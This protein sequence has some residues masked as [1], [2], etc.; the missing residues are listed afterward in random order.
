MAKPIRASRL[1]ARAQGP[2]LPPEPCGCDRD[3]IT[4][5]RQLFVDFFQGTGIAAGRDPATRPVFLRL[6]G[7]A[8]GWFRVEPDL[9]EPL[10][11]GVLG[12]HGEYPAWIRFSSDVQPGTPDLKSTIGIAI[13]LFGV[14]GEK[15]LPPDQHAVTHDFV[16]QNHDVFFVDTAR[17]MCEF[18][19]QSLHGKL[20]DYLRAHPETGR[21]LD[22]MAKTVDSVLASAYWSVLPSR[23]GADRYVKYKIEP[24]LVPP[25]SPPDHA[26]PE[27]LAADLRARLRGG[28]A[29][30]RFLIQLRSDEAAMPL[31]RA[32]VRWDESASPPVHVA[33]LVVPMQDVAARGQATYGENLSFNPWRAL[34]AHAPVGS[35]AE[36]RKIVYAA[37]AANRRDV[38]GVPRGEPEIPRP[39]DF[40]G[41]DYPAARDTAIVRAAIHPAIGVA[42][43]GPSDEYYI[44]PEVPDSPPAQPGE[45]RDATGALKRQAAR[46]RIFGYNAAGEVVR[47]LTADWA[48]IEWRVRVANRK[49]AWY[50][51]QIALD[52]PEAAGVAV[53]LRNAKVTGAAREA[54][55]IDSGEV[56]ISG[57]STSGPAYAL[58]GTFTGVRVALGELRTDDAGR[59]V[60]LGGHGVA[61]SPTGAPIYNDDDPN[62]FINADDW[63]DDVSDGPVTASVSIAGRAIVVEPAWVMTAPPD[64]A[65]SIKAVRTLYDLLFDLYVNAGWLAAPATIGFHRDVHPILLRLVGLQW[66]NQGFLTQYGR[67]APNDFEQPDYVARLSRPPAPGAYD[68]HGELRRQVLNSFRSPTVADGNQLP[69]PWLYG[70]AM[71]YPAGSSP[72]Q[73]AA[74]SWTQYRILQR[75]AAGDFVDDT[76]FAPPTSLDAVPLAA[77]PATLDRA[78]LEH[79]LADAFHPG[80]EVT[81]PIR[82][83]TMF[84]APFRIRHRPD[85]APVPNLG[86]K[87]TP[88]EALSLDGPLYAQGPGDLTRWMGLPWH[89]DT[90]Y[91]RSGYD[92]SYD[93]LIPT[94]WPARVPNQVLGPEDYAVV[95]D[96]S[97]PRDQR[98]AAFTDRTSWTEPLVGTTAEQMT[99]MVRIFGSMGL[100]ELR[101]GVSG[102]PV[103][104]AQMLVASYGPQVAPSATSSFARTLAVAAPRVEAPAAAP[105]GAGAPPASAAAPHPRGASFRS[106]DEAARAPLPVRRPGR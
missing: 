45:H 15:Q 52:I 4:G 47:E 96:P 69:W 1:D 70:D 89:A 6:H 34:A 100:L 104:P 48:R 25:G 61:A 10:R 90:A 57:V 103:L 95:I 84:S 43:V 93:P 16:L 94:F 67:T 92:T 26:D 21:I 32:T 27:Y 54:L 86:G 28:E 20:D 80:C 37:S 62:A 12:Q 75:W 9:P 22:D 14:T 98:I 23:F 30:F 71:E 72:R 49:A 46:F 68:V 56:A 85:G 35:I 53:P 13:K 7:V 44:G 64:Y 18:T 97:R 33:T 59:L 60:V 65:P 82:H 19:C 88:A 17:D 91:C 2:T 105:A 83:L 31:D 41:D 24:E 36:A 102:D 29:R 11:V 77:Q 40:H 74:L 5:L 63:Y 51:W 76:G 78:A 66:V 3:P 106:A 79:C 8:H 99:Q 73:N 87:L 50:Q 101:P 42:R 39:P 55:V 81:W 58:A 38:N